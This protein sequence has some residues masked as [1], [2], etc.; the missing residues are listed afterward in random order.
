MMF[1]AGQ[2]QVGQRWID[3]RYTISNWTEDGNMYR[4]VPPWL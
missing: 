3:W 1:S 4:T 2:G